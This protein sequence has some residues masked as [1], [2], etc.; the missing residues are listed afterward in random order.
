PCGGVGPRRA[1][2][3]GRRPPPPLAAGDADTD[4]LA[5]RGRYIATVGTCPLCHTAGPNP[6]RLWSPYPEMGG[7]MRVA[8]RVFG[9]T[10][11][12]NLTPPP[13]TGLGAWSGPE[14]R[15]AFPSRVPPGAPTIHLH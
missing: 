14:G 5:Q 2:P 7:G 4:A 9:T 10:Y 11:S 13:S 12:R 8:W 6:V 1:R 15:T 3:P